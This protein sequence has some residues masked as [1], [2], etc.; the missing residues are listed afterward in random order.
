VPGLHGLPIKATHVRTARGV[1]LKPHDA[2]CVPLCEV[3]HK[4][5]HR[6]AHPQFDARHRIQLLALVRQFVWQAPDLRMRESVL[7]LPDHLGQFFPNEL[8][9]ELAAQ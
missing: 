5:Q 2:L 9:G 1:K 4:E 7:R 3:H 6:N 8:P